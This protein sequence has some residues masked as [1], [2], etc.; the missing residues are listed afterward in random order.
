MVGKHSASEML[1]VEARTAS[2]QTAVKL[3]PKQRKARWPHD[4]PTAEA[5]AFAGFFYAPY[6]GS[7]DNVCCYLCD[8]NMSGWEATDDP[9]REH[10]RGNHSCAWAV[11][12]DILVRTK[13]GDEL[14]E[15]DDPTSEKMVAL[16]EATFGIWWPHDLKKGWNPKSKKV[17]SVYFLTRLI[18][19]GESGVLLYAE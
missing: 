1:S 18:V 4:L 7:L 10:L 3:A 13:N 9:L 17:Q 19:D 15:E 11:T 6:P 8:K 14:C 16:R 12:R 2:F 5:L